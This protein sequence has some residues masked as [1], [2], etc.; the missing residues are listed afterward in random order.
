M[1]PDR[2]ARG[3]LSSQLRAMK[4]PESRAERDPF[5]AL[6]GFAD[7]PENEPAADSV[8]E[9]LRRAQAE[10][11]IDQQ[12]PATPPEGDAAEA[13]ADPPFSAADS[14]GFDSNGSPGSARPPGSAAGG[15]GGA[16]ARKVLR[17]LVAA[18]NSLRAQQ[19]DN[20]QRINTLLTT[21]I[22]LR[23][24]GWFLLLLSILDGFEI[25]YS[26]QLMNPQSEL[27]A[28]GALIEKSAIPLLGIGLIFWGGVFLRGRWEAPVIKGLSWLCIL[29]GLF[30]LAMAPLLVLDAYRIDQARMG[31][32]AAEEDQVKA[33][34]A[35]VLTQLE[36][37]QTKEQL[38]RVLQGVIA[39]PLV[40]PPD[41][42]LAE[43]KS[44]LQQAAA[45]QSSDRLALIERKRGDDRVR[46][47]MSCA[48]WAVGAVF[49]GAVLLGVWFM[50]GWARV[51][52]KR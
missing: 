32:L 9:S 51:T 29:L 13:A 36:Q 28:M 19:A 3:D 21:V 48:K 10:R 1:Q 45:K 35:Q 40:A 27:Q 38:E 50:T 6:A 47:W 42:P 44:M 22:P 24:I 14:E 16:E 11:K 7:D 8:F 26:V 30:Y 18:N 12:R 23:W 15:D 2:P 52:P 41:K 43:L 25:G 33:R 5:E 46:F 17:Q 4:I 49:A 37:M 20:G 34:Q 31:Q 39:R